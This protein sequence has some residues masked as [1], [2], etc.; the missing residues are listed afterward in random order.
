MATPTLDEVARKLAD[1][2]RRVDERI[3]IPLFDVAGV[4]IATVE[5]LQEG[6]N[7]TLA[8]QT[9]D[10][11]RLGTIASSGGGGGAPTNA[12]YLTLAT[13]ATL[14]AERVLTPGTDLAGVDSGAGAP[15]T[16]NHATGSTGT[17]HL[18]S[19]P[20]DWK[21]LGSA[22]RSFNYAIEVGVYA[23]RPAAS[24]GNVGRLYMAT[25]RANTVYICT[26]ATT[27]AV[28]NPR[29]VTLSWYQDGS[30]RAD[31]SNAQGPIRYLPDLDG[32]T[33]ESVALWKPVRCKV[34]A[35]VAPTGA[36]L[37]VQIEFG[38]TTTP[39]T[40]LFASGDRPTIAASAL[41]G[42]STTFADTAI[43]N[44]TAFERVIDQ[45]GSTIPGADLSVELEFV[46]IDA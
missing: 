40:D 11:K 38:T 3:Q 39:G 10:L 46:Q 31:A 25:D 22:G 34:H 44:G 33:T 42:T 16:L 19:A 30:L 9:G 7:I 2:T 17:G 13:D 37:I 43:E 27:W 24:S 23:S 21:V 35:R 6:A 4:Q 41:E 45:V 32:M 15:Y 18:P 26:N 12:Q 29:H 20:S 8:R 28:L 5:G 14:T 1:L 36:D